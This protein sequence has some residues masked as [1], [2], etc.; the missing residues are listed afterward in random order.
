MFKSPTLK[1]PDV[2]APEIVVLPVVVTSAV[3]VV[4]VI[5]TFSLIVTCD[6][7]VLDISVPATCIALID[8]APVPLG[9][10]EISAFDPFDVIEFVVN[11][12]A[13]RLPFTIAPPLKVVAP[14]TPNVVLKLP[15]VPVNAPVTSNA[16]A[17]VIFVESAALKV[18]PLNVTAPATTFPVPPGVKFISAFDGYEIEL[19]F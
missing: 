15:D 6:E 7:S 10:I 9:W 5:L 11:D 2:N 3:F 19:S 13:V 17:T 12:P 16:S 14:V 4:P 1:V 8:T 18:V